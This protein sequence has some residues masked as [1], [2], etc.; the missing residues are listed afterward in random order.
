MRVF[1]NTSSSN[2]FFL[3]A[4]QIV[5]VKGPC[6]WSAYNVANWN[7]R[8]LEHHD[9]YNLLWEDSDNLERAVVEIITN[10]VS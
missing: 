7:F 1:L 4:N 3:A 2:T 6:Q 5:L 10:T 8:R 9:I